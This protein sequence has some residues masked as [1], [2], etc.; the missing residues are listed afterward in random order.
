MAASIS[1]NCSDK[2]DPVA[3]FPYTV[4]IMRLQPQQTV[5][6]CDGQGRSLGQVV[7]AKIE[8]DLVVGQFTP[9]PAF[10]TVQPLFDEFVEAVNDELFHR[11][12][13]LDKALAALGL[14][15]D[16][17]DGHWMPLIHDVQIAGPDISFRIQKNG[18]GEA[19]AHRQD[20][21]KA[22]FIDRESA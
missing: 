14:R 18:N 6:L 15:L 16:A 3:R 2:A 5:S 22:Q 20:H 17:P 19:F 12:D 10:A 13:E 4:L 8:G 9:T 1:L 11:V 7:I 21:D